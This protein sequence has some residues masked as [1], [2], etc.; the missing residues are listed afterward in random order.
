MDSA[1]N[2]FVAGLPRSCTAWLSVFLS[3]SGQYCYHE[4]INGC[5]SRKEYLNKLGGCGDSSTGLMYLSINE[6]FPDSP[7]II[8]E[9]NTKQLKHCVEWGNKVFKVDTG[10]QIMQANELLRSMEGLRVKQ[11][12]IFDRLP[13]IFTYLTRTPWDEKYARLK[14]LNI[15]S[16]PLN[17]DLESARIFMNETL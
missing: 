6:L 14:D 5:K 17:M 12:D 1:L 15:Q 10:M 13:E 8:I 7:V 2:Y 16:D 9:K 11:S 3:Q 4:A